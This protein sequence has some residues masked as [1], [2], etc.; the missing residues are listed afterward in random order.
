MKNKQDSSIQS[1]PNPYLDFPELDHTALTIPNYSRCKKTI[2]I[3]RV[4]NCYRRPKVK[5]ATM[6]KN[7]SGLER[8]S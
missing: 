8:S 3:C 2:E 4:T 1:C 6:N 7:G 5:I